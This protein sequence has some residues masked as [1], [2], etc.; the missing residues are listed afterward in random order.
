MDTVHQYGEKVY[1]TLQRSLLRRGA[2]NVMGSQKKAGIGILAIFIIP[3]IALFLFAIVVPAI[4]AI[5]YSLFDWSNLTNPKWLGVQNFVKLA[6]DALFWQALGNNLKLALYTLVGQLGIGY[7]LAFV[8]SSK[9]IKWSNFHRTV[10]FFPAMISTVVLGF[11]WM[12]IYNNNYGIL[13]SLLKAVGLGNLATAWLSNPHGIIEVL[14]VPL[15]WQWFG[16]YMVIFMGAIATIPAEIM[17]SAEIDGCSSWQRMVHISVPMT[18]DTIVVCILLCLAGIM[19]TFDHVLVMTAGGPGTSS[20]VLALY[21]YK[22][23]FSGMKVGYG[24]AISVGITFFSLLISFTARGLL[25]RGGKQ[26]D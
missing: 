2:C 9:L 19:K 10:M 4:L 6:K 21:A 7:V 16:F 14:A 1:G 5:G 18:Y 17:E 15:I 20:M 24:N 25:N 26:Y 13:N 12:L 22:T 23:T 3:G 8:L 11:L